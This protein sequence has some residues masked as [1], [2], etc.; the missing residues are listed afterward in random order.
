MRLSSSPVVSVVSQGR[1]FQERARTFGDACSEGAH[2]KVLLFAGHKRRMF[3]SQVEKGG[4]IGLDSTALIGF[5]QSC[6]GVLRCPWVLCLV[7]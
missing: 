2:G 6:A 7:L 3:V 5:S 1:S 4:I